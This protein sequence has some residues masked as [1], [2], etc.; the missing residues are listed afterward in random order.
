MAIGD[1]VDASAETARWYPAKVMDVREDAL[2]VQYKL[3]EAPSEFALTVSVAGDLSDEV[4]AALTEV[5]KHYARAAGDESEG[6]VSAAAMDRRAIGAAISVATN[7]VCQQDDARVAQILARYANGSGTLLLDEFLEYWR[8]RLGGTQT[9]YLKDEIQRLCKRAKVEVGAQDERS[10]LL[11]MNQEWVPIASGRLARYRLHLAEYPYSYSRDRDLRDFR[12][13]DSVDFLCDKWRRGK[14]VEVDAT[15]SASASKSACRTTVPTATLGPRRST[16]RGERR[17]A[18]GLDSRVGASQSP[19]PTL[20]KT[21][22]PR[23][24]A[25]GARPARARA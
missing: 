20:P 12:T 1:D 6:I 11:R 15:S 8:S 13:Y 17:G 22:N 19:T 24:R 10:R 2:L 4:R 7:T 25:N 23:R 21:T 14:V 18:S 3:R 5:F 9:F 16:P